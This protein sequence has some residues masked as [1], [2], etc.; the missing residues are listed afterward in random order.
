LL[1]DILA[2]KQVFFQRKASWQ[3]FYTR[4]IYLVL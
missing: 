2:R 1:N 4:G 3:E